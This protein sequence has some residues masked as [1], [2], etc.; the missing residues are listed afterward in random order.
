MMNLISD[1]ETS[2]S[3]KLFLYGVI[4]SNNRLLYIHTLIYI[5]GFFQCL[6][7]L[8]HSSNPWISLYVI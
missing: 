7:Y 3:E 2:G 1:A 5:F 4:L 8:S 6:K